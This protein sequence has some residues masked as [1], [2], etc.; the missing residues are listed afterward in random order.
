MQF[1]VR[2]DNGKIVGA[3]AL[4]RWEHPQKGLLHPG[5]YIGLMESEGTIG[6]LDFYIFEEACRQLERWQKEGR[7]LS[8]S[9]NFTR[10]T[11]NQ[12]DFVSRLQEIAERYCFDRFYLII[13]ITEDIMEKNRKSALSNVAQCKKLGFRIAL[14]DLGSGYTS[15]ADLRD[16]PIDGIKLDRSL[17]NFAVNPQ[18]IALLRG[19]IE[20]AHS[21]QMAVLCE[22]VETIQQVE[23]LRDLDCDYMQGYY[24]YRALPALEATRYVRENDGKVGT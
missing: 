18:G 2:G 22:G 23:L 20:L 13:E 9:C 11:I 5:S 17:L 15:F 24:F 8:I 3:E 6:E 12:K 4:S 21:L 1:I 7:K 10:F 16:Y 19:V 14:D